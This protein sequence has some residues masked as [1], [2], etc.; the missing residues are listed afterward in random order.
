VEERVGVPLREEAHTLTR[1]VHDEGSDARKAQDWAVAALSVYPLVP[2]TL[3]NE[4]G[5]AGVVSVS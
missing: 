1:P 2:E 5:Q 4:R 3:I